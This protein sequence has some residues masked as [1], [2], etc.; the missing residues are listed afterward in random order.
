MINFGLDSILSALELTKRHLSLALF[1]IADGKGAGIPD[2]GYKSVMENNIR[3]TAK[4]CARLLL[5]SSEDRLIRLWG[6][7]G[8]EFTI[9]ELAAELKPL[10]EAIEDDL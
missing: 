5:P 8:R 7:W 6:M 2:P 9:S 4:Q 10:V 1:Q 3:Y